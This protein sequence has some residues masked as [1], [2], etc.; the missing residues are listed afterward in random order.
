M[1]LSGD[2]VLDWAGWKRETSFEDMVKEMVDSDRE[3]IQKSQTHL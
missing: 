3:L 1:N 2:I